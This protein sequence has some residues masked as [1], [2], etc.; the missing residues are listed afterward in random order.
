[1]IIPNSL[2]AFEAMNPRV[3]IPRIAEP[4]AV[5]IRSVSADTGEYKVSRY[6]SI[7][8]VDSIFF[9]ARVPPDSAPFYLLGYGHTYVAGEMNDSGPGPNIETAVPFYS[10]KTGQFAGYP[11][12]GLDISRAFYDY[13][14]PASYM[15]DLYA[16]YGS[17]QPDES[18]STGGKIIMG[19][20]L[21][22]IGGALL[23]PLFVSAPAI[24]TVGATGLELEAV[25]GTGMGLWVEPSI[26]VS[27]IAS[28]AS[29]GATGLEVAAGSGVQW[30]EP[31]SGG[32]TG[33]GIFKDIGASALGTGKSLVNSL[34]AKEVSSLFSG[35][36]GVKSVAV[37]GNKS[38]FPWLWI[39]LIGFTLIGAFILT[40][41]RRN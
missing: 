41:K 13:D 11:I 2:P 27:E 34:V 16:R 35:S 19:G 8:N 18:I 20:A 9:N 12:P 23:S 7:G 38:S 40:R 4:D 15:S 33:N 14:Y 31:A 1:M 21:A 30:A 17:W 32:F 3:L 29:A 6:Q 39:V 28:G 36:K 22:V 26:G 24:E 10:L 25:S 5:L 37:V